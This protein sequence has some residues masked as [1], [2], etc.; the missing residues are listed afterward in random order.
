MAGRGLPSG[1]GRGWGPPGSCAASGGSAWSPPVLAALLLELIPACRARPGPGRH[2]IST[3][4]AGAGTP[5]EA[6]DHAKISQQRATWAKA[7]VSSNL[8]AAFLHICGSRCRRIVRAA[9]PLS[10][11][12]RFVHDHDAAS[13]AWVR[14]PGLGGANPLR[15]LPS[16]GETLQRVRLASRR[17]IRALWA[18]DGSRREALPPVVAA[19]SWRG[20]PRTLRHVGLP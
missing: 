17:D 15:V 9:A 11:A 18:I 6:G 20:G 8:S 7:A 3:R 16:D 1:L 10:A 13:R 5:S 4:Q 19:A 2:V 12:R 14:G